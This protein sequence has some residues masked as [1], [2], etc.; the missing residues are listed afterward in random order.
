MIGGRALKQTR[1][2]ILPGVHLNHIQTDKFK[3]AV[4]SISLLAQ[5]ERETASDPLCAPPR[6]G[7]L[8]GY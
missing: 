3:I 2:E 5:L 1:K 6:N 7:P 8:R 4:M